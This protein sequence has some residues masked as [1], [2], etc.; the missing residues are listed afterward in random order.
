VG[1]IHMI[2]L[3]WSTLQNVGAI[4]MI[5]LQWSTLQNVGAIHWF[6]F[7]AQHYKMWVQFIGP[8]S[9]LSHVQWINEFTQNPVKALDKQGCIL[10]ECS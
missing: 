5:L 7:N 1:A 4:H 9:S 8:C 2:L 3:Q 10:L 6:L